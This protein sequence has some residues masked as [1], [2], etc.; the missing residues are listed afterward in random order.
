MP[1]SG[2]GSKLKPSLRALSLSHSPALALSLALSLSL[3]LTCTDNCA[4][5]QCDHV[6]GVTWLELAE[7]ADG[8]TSSFVVDFTWR[9]ATVE[10]FINA[11]PE[12]STKSGL[13]KTDVYNEE[14]DEWDSLKF[15]LMLW[16]ASKTVGEMERTDRP[17]SSGGGASGASTTAK[18]SPAPE[19]A[20]Q[21]HK[22]VLQLVGKGA[23][24]VYH[25]SF[26]TINPTY[27]VRAPAKCVA[28][29]LVG[30]SDHR[31]AFG[32]A[33]GQAGYPVRVLSKSHSTFWNVC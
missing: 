33:R 7:T 23:S 20:L 26:H 12:A 2:V 31:H 14:E 5:F 17:G 13:V 22:V 4:Q 24:Q 6:I 9:A 19:S 10:T 11:G 30:C 21:Q 3:S 18:V 25:L 28:S 32:G 1:S 29:T 15:R 27:Q 8:E 16:P